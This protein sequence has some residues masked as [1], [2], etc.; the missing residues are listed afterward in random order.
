MALAGPAVRP[1]AQRVVPLARVAVRPGTQRVVSLAR[2]AVRP[3]AQRVVSLA[4]SPG[5]RRGLQEPA[6][7]ATVSRALLHPTPIGARKPEFGIAHLLALT[8]GIGVSCVSQL[9]DRYIMQSFMSFVSAIPPSTC[10]MILSVCHHMYH[11]HVS[12]VL[13]VH[14]QASPHQFKG[15]HHDS[16][17]SAS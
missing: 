13:P 5:S 15:Q 14:I 4:G 6:G 7:A 1:G 12:T 9:T 16:L 2:V 3:G 10:V 17:P 11:C 8:P